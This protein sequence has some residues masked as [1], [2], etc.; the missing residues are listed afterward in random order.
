MA[1]VEASYQ[2]FEFWRGMQLWTSAVSD[3]NTLAG[4]FFGGAAFNLGVGYWIC[5]LGVVGV[6]AA[7]IVGFRL[8]SNAPAAT[9]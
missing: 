1:E 3:R 2:L 5:V 9:P 7:G 4:M 6:L 8:S